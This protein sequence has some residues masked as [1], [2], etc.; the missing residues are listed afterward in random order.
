MK[1]QFVYEISDIHCA[2]CAKK[3]SLALGYT[4]GVE[5]TEV[6]LKNKT[7]VVSLDLARVTT[8]KIKGIIVALGF[9]AMLV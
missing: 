6:S 5:S 9:S 8:S 4:F 1:Q 7:A 3:I 2:R